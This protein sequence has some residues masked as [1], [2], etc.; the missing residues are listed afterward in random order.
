MHS[1]ALT[2][3]NLSKLIRHYGLTC[4]SKVSDV[5]T[6]T[7]THFYTSNTFKSTELVLVYNNSKSSRL[8][9]VHNMKPHTALLELADK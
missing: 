3:I 6:N 1:V 4:T 9:I 8:I 7:D 2:D 5:D